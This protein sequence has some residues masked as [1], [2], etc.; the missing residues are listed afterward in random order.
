MS[1][2][3]DARESSETT[4]NGH[5]LGLK[6][7][8]RDNPMI[9]T[10]KSEKQHSPER[11]NVSS[12][13]GE[14]RTH[15]EGQL[16]ACLY[17]TCLH[18]K[19]SLKNQLFLSFGLVSTLSLGVLIVTAILM[20]QHAGSHVKE[21]SRED[22]ELATEEKLSAA[23]RIIAE[24][25]AAGLDH[26]KGIPSILVETT[27]DRFVGYP[28]HPGYADDSLVPF[29]DMVSGRNVYPLSASTLLPLDWN[30]EPIDI[31]DENADEHLLGRRDWYSG[32]IIGTGAYI[33][34]QGAC[35]PEVTNQSARGY[36]AN[37]TDANSDLSTGGA[38][39]P[40]STYELIHR[41]VSDYA[42]AVLKPLFEADP[43]VI[44]T[45][46]YFANSGAG[47][48]VSYPSLSYEG[49]NT[50]TSDGCAWLLEPNPL[51][52]S[53]TIGT[54]EM[55]DRCHPAGDEVESWFYNP[56]ERAWCREQALDPSKVRFF[57]PYLDAF[58]P[59]GVLFTVGRAVFDR[60]TNEF[61]A[62]T[63][64]DVSVA[65]MTRKIETFKITNMT[66]V[67]L[68]KWDD[69]TVVTSTK[70]NVTNSSRITTIFDIDS[71]VDAAL[72]SDMKQQF[73]LSLENNRD[74]PQLRPVYPSHENVFAMHPIPVSPK[75]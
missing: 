2:L 32:T 39:Q 19:L 9:E 49:W 44:G 41:K 73:T 3:T 31:T 13:F 69:G 33:S 74:R 55:V 36:V 75:R 35:N 51:D 20:I 52:S 58:L 14:H 72:F 48:F 34:F 27:R 23:S 12:D 6:R 56:L 54:E 17:K 40:T 60:V 4:T 21:L 64:A 66:D 15:I 26:I 25:V 5:L 62:C 50:Y 11:R 1:G 28:D 22:L 63:L 10:T 70:W 65:E 38:V 47:A 53:K 67:H 18:Q 42:T 59:D 16:D 29:R 45:G 43:L 46:I 61:I 7:S 57:G 37:C 24:S 68:V 71:G 30:F 8:E